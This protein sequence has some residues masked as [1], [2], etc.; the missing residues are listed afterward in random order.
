MGPC[1]KTSQNCL[2]PGLFKVFLKSMFI[3]LLYPF[4]DTWAID[5]AY[6]IKVLIPRSR[7]KNSDTES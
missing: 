2:T 1:I 4:K 6:R 7:L 3:L 5:E